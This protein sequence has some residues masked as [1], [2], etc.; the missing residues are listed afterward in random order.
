M[1]SHIPDADYYPPSPPFNHPRNITV[2]LARVIYV[3]TRGDIEGH[4]ALPG[5][6]RTTDRDRA[7]QCAA[8]MNLEMSGGAG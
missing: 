6:Q 2:G 1:T 5:S 7:L 4:W 8:A 3:E